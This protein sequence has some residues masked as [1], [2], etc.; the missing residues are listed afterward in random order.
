ML[1]QMDQEEIL[2]RNPQIDPVELER[3]QEAIRRLREQRVRRKEY[4]LESPFRG[5]RPIVR[6]D[7]SNDQRI[8]RLRRSY[9]T[10]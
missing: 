3:L 6:E 10:E 7:P 4:E 2:S 1:E 5:R 9:S 8:V